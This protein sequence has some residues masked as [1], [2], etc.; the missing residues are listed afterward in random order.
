[1]I[2][3]KKTGRNALCK[4]F[5]LPWEQDSLIESICVSIHTFSTL[6]FPPKKHFT[7]FTTFPLCGNFFVQSWK[8]SALSLT[9]CLV[10]NIWCSPY[11]HQTLI[12]GRELKP[13]FWGQQRSVHIDPWTFL[14]RIPVHLFHSQLPEAL[15]PP[16]ITTVPANGAAHLTLSPGGSRGWKTWS[17]SLV[18][19]PGWAKWRN[20]WAV[21]FLQKEC[22]QIFMLQFF[23][24]W[25]DLWG[26]QILLP[27]MCW[28]MVDRAGEI[29]FKRLRKLS[30]FT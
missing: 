28:L 18:S 23:L 6:S 24:E 26:Q 20:T 4:W 11:H 14:C 2:G 10:A 21:K 3:Q 16:E 19:L 15:C 9:T 29:P 12:S 17:L 1:M 8:A 13:Y 22:I 27:R 25:E 7:C 30:T 5:K